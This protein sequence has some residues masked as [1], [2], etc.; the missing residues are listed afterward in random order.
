[1]AI[2]PELLQK[3]FVGVKTAY[4][5]GEYDKA[6]SNAESALAMEGSSKSLKEEAQLVKANVLVDGG[7]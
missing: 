3:A 4:E 1:M 6:Y 7:I 2:N 5:L